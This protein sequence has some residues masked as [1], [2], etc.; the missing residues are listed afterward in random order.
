MWLQLSMPWATA[1][2]GRTPGLEHQRRVA[3][4]LQHTDSLLVVLQQLIWVILRSAGRS[5]HVCNTTV[6]ILV[7]LPCESAAVALLRLSYNT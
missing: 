3:A 2:A 6:S 1:E 5:R 7:A 4:R